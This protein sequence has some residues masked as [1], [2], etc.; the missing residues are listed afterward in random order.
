[1][2]D[3]V[4]RINR[5]NVMIARRVVYLRRLVIS[6]AAARRVV[7]DRLN[8]MGRARLEIYAGLIRVLMGADRCDLAVLLKGE[9]NANEWLTCVLRVVSIT[10]YRTG[11]HRN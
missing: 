3:L 10:K 5:V 2:A 11:R 6:A 8:V 7:A 1:M 9:R 4:R